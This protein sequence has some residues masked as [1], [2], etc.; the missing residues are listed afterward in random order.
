MLKPLPHPAEASRLDTLVELGL[1]DPWE[2]AC[3]ERVVR[4]VKRHFDTLMCA[5]T[6]VD[7]SRVLFKARQ[8][9]ALTEMP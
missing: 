9:L 1:Q 4:L 5:F 6:V 8:G 7:S 2:E 3:F